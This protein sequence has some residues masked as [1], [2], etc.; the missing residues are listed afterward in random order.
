[1]AGRGAH[2]FTRASAGEFSRRVTLRLQSQDTRKFLLSDA[3]RRVRNAAVRSGGTDVAVISPK[4]R[5]QRWC[6]MRSP[7]VNKTSREHF[8]MVT[9]T[10]VVEWDADGSADREAPEVIARNLPA[11]VAGRLQDD[12]PGL[13]AL[14]V[15]WDLMQRRGETAGTAG[16]GEVATK[17]ADVPADVA[18]DGGV[19]KTSS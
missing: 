13:M 4:K 9:H 12:V 8:W 10:R 17:S 5:I 2:N 16:E 11:T 7:H 1:M 15:A 3:V 19:E 6:V 14:P 18:A